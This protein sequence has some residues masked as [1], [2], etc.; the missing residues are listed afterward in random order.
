MGP[1]VG[2]GNVP[3]AKFSGADV[4][5]SMDICTCTCVHGNGS[6]NSLKWLGSSVVW[7][8]GR[9]LSVEKGSVLVAVVDVSTSQL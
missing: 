4:I 1:M 5:M 9:V 7:S 3:Q 6:H 8:G 2:S